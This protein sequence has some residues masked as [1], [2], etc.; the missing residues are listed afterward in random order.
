MARRKPFKDP[1]DFFECGSY[2]F[3]DE[4]GLMVISL[5]PNLIE[6]LGIKEG[7]GFIWKDY[8]KNSKGETILRVELSRRS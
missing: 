2:V 3:K 4:R 5:P 6:K 7:D 8:Y 1:K